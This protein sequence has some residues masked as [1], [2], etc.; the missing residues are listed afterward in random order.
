MQCNAMQKKKK[1]L[2]ITKHQ[3]DYES[4]THNLYL[5]GSGLV[6]KEEKDD[7]GLEC[8]GKIPPKTTSP[9]W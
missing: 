8:K 2:N 5:V 1:N 9:P 3:S 4:M 7:M 6:L